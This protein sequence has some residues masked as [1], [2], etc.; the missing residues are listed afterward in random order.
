MDEFKVDDTADA[1][2]WEGGANIPMACSPLRDALRGGDDL[3]VQVWTL[4]PT[5]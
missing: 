1:V 4:T 5:T 2:D 3:N